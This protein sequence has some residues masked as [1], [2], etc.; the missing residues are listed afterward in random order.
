MEGEAC[1]E[2]PEVTNLDLETGDLSDSSNMSSSY[3][4]SN[5]YE[6]ENAAEEEIVLV[7]DMTDIQK[8]A[9][10]NFHL[11]DISKYQFVSL[12]V[13]YMFYCWFAKMSGFAVRKECT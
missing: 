11:A 7:R 10:D 8:L 9:A 3:G 6:S 12:D 4:N 1:H 5:E 13:A 2:S